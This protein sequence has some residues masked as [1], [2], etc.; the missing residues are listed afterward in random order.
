MNFLRN[1]LFLTLFTLT[2]GLSTYADEVA[3]LE[4]KIGAAQA[5]AVAKKMAEI[6]DTA[7]LEA[8]QQEMKDIKA[9][10]DHTQASK[11]L[12]AL[13]TKHNEVWPDAPQFQ[14]KQYQKLGNQIEAYNHKLKKEEEKSEVDK[15]RTAKKE[16]FE[17]TNFPSPLLSAISATPFHF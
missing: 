5:Q 10:Q 3:D 6:N 16:Q 9:L 12:L 11:R 13:S 7:T 1:I 4:R 8:L 2:F 15:E 17:Q 14:L